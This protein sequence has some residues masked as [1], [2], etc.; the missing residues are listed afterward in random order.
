MN[1]ANYSFDEWKFRRVAESAEKH[2][3]IA[4][5]WHIESL[6]LL[7]TYGGSSPTNAL[8]SAKYSIDLLECYRE[9]GNI[10]AI[11]EQADN[12]APTI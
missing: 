12:K 5:A 3:Y 11:M 9:G 2:E 1:E 6:H 8:N 10:D 4:L 7:D